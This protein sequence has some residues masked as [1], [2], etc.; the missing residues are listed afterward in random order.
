MVSAVQ[1]AREAYQTKQPARFCGTQKTPSTLP[2]AN[3]NLE[4]SET[5]RQNSDSSHSRALLRRP[6]LQGSYP[7]LDALEA[8]SMLHRREALEL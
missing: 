1:A 4:V 7:G 2:N 8:P 6:T 3:D 5:R